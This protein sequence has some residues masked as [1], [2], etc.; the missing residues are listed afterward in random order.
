[1]TK[2]KAD[3]V[4]KFYLNHAPERMKLLTNVKEVLKW[5]NATPF[6]CLGQIGYACCYCDDQFPDPALLKKHTLDS[7]CNEQ[8]AC[9]MKTRDMTRFYVKVD[10]TELHCNI[11]LNNC[12][13][14]DQIMQHLYSDHNK[15]LFMEVK[16]YMVP[17]KFDSDTLRCFICLNKFNRFK[18]L[19]EH[20]NAHCRNFICE[21]CDA[22]F[23]TRTSLTNHAKIHETG[24]FSCKFCDKVFSTLS[25]K[26]SHEKYVHGGVML[27]KCGHCNESFKDY[28]KKIKHMMDVH[29]VA[30]ITLKCHACDRTFT[31]QKVYRNHTKRDHLMERRYKCTQCE[32]KFY[33]SNELKDHSIKHTGVRKFQCDVCL[34]AYGRKSTLREHMR[35]HADDRRFKCEHCGMAFVQKCSWRGHMRAK[36]GEQ[37]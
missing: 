24:T 9:F 16:N 19:L 17:F 11:C 34:K 28:H 37:V 3:D 18:A 8:T 10:I 6:R 36:H 13:T 5:S 7:H 2:L 27:N 1:M 14:L 29:G 4:R 15:K 33:T 22:G 20:M 30:P 12:D 23:I 32:M 31:N 21:V 26:K 25:R 35:I